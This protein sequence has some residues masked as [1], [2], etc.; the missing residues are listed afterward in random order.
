M[1]RPPPSHP[2]F[3]LTTI[4]VFTLCLHPLSSAAPLLA[5][6]TEGPLEHAEGAAGGPPAATATRVRT[7]S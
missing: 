1:S 5:N 2:R 3:P 6:T 7:C 4:T